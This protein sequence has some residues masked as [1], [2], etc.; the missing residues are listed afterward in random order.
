MLSLGAMLSIV[1]ATSTGAVMLG[2]GV[3]RE[4]CVSC[5]PKTK[6]H[7]SSAIS[8]TETSGMTIQS[9]SLR[10]DRSEV[11]GLLSCCSSLWYGGGVATTASSSL[12]S[13][14]GMGGGGGGSDGVAE[15][16]ACGWGVQAGGVLAGRG[17]TMHSA[18]RLEMTD[19]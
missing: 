2:G 1:G 15:V 18:I 13:L 3:V 16:S 7:S 14:V 17:A 12:L 19:G 6:N 10:F 8:R 5:L 4:L 11:E 9:H